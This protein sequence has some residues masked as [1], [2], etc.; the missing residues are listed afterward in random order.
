MGNNISKTGKVIVLFFI[1]VAA[2]IIYVLRLFSMQITNGEEYKIQSR[3]I[4][5][6]ISTLPASRG[7]IYD[8]NADIPLVI[9]NDSFAVEVTPGEIPAAKYDTVMVK[10]A[11]YLGIPKSTIDEKIPKNVRRSYST[12][13]VKTNVPFS[14]ISNI[15]ENL[16]DLP[17]VSWVSK[18]VRNYA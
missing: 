7:E 1:T 13:Q 17:G 16:S 12:I 15:A 10:L 8:R 9:N 5:S 4:S 6:Q 11:G 3:T 2:F 18:P 14:I